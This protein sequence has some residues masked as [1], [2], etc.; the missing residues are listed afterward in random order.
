[1]SQITT[2]ILDTCKGKPAT[3]VSVILFKQNSEKAAGIAQHRPEPGNARGSNHPCT[4]RVKKA[5]LLEKAS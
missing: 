2:H 4:T 1:M 5:D 3:T